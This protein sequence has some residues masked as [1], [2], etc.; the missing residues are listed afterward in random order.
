MY[1]DL[2]E[3]AAISFGRSVWK[4]EIMRLAFGKVC[5]NADGKTSNKR[6]LPVKALDNI[7]TCLESDVWKRWWLEIGSKRIQTNGMKLMLGGGGED[8]DT[9]IRYIK[10]AMARRKRIMNLKS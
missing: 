10:R 1:D 4:D 9:A 8:A 7:A 2:R 3:D 5:R 6:R